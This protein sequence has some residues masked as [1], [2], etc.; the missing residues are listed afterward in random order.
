LELW[1]EFDLVLN[2]GAEFVDPIEGAT[3]TLLSG[4]DVG[5]VRSVGVEGGKFVGAEAIGLVVDGTA[6]ELRELDAGADVVLAVAPGDDFVDV[7]RIFGFCRVSLGA[8]A[9]EGA[10]DLDGLRV[11]DALG[12]VFV[13]LQGD[14][15]L[16]DEVGGDDDAVV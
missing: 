1:T 2:E 4:E 6:A 15:K 13:L 10:A 16:V 9:D 14:L 8:T 3:G 11:G 5:C 12:D 7:D